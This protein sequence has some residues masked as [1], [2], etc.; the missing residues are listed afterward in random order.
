MYMY[1]NNIYISLSYIP[2]SISHICYTFFISF[3]SF[4]M[5]YVL[6]FVVVKSYNRVD[7]F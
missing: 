6:R 7:A 4:H 2:A 5:S 3:N 1:T